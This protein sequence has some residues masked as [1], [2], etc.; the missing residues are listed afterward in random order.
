MKRIIFSIILVIACFTTTMAQVNV[1]GHIVNTEGKAIEYVSVI[2]LDDSIGVI[3]DAD[4]HFEIKVRKSDVQ[5]AFTHV[6]YEGQTVKASDLLRNKEVVMKEKSVE[7]PDVSIAT[8]KKQKTITGKGMRGPGNVALTGYGQSI[9]EVGSVTSVSKTCTVEQIS[10]PIV[11]SSYDKCKL[12]FHF[13]EIDGKK[14]VPIQTVPIYVDVDKCGKKTLTVEPAEKI[15]LHKG[16]RYFT[17]V[18]LVEL[19]GTGSVTFP[20]YFKSGYVRNLESGKQ[21]KLPISLGIEIKG[22]EVKE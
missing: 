6:S 4:G 19:R 10:I 1:K 14:F 2:A 13:Y 3:S 7:L 15:V 16:H 22:R 17:S 20:A 18:S 8:G 9:R 11:G 12:S 21:K 5:L